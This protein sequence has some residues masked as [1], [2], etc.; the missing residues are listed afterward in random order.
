MK[1]FLKICMVLIFI[2]VACA[3]NPSTLSKEE[4]VLQHLQ[5]FSAHFKQVLKNEKP[6]VYYGVLKAKA[7]NWALWVYEKP[8]KKEIYMNDKEVVIYEPNLFQATIT[9]LKDKT[10]FFTILKRLKKQDDGSFKTTINKTTY[11]LVF[12][13]GKPFS[14]EFKDD[15]N[16]LVTITF[17]QAEINPTIINEIFVFKPKDENIDIVRQ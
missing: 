1:A 13:D 14:L 4:E 2:G 7:P 15:M 16:N 10:D 12:K 17:S 9:P 5:S 3:K 6:L 11:R 8:L